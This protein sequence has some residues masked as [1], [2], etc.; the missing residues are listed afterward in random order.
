MGAKRFIVTIVAGLTAVS[1]LLAVSLGLL[2]WGGRVDSSDV[3]A[4]V[5]AAFKGD[6][7]HFTVNTANIK[8]A[9]RGEQAVVYSAPTR[10]GGRCDFVVERNKPGSE[11]SETCADVFDSTSIGYGVQDDGTVTARDA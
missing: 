3:P 9:K 10:E 5:K 2:D 6:N 7:P 4:D 1:V 11:G 8:E